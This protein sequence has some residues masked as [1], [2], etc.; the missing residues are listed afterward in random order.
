VLFA[1][2]ASDTR[3]IALV[4]GIFE[5]ADA[6]S[7]RVCHR[8]AWFTPYTS[9]LAFWYVNGKHNSHLLGQVDIV[10]LGQ[11]DSAP[12]RPKTPICR[13]TPKMMTHKQF[14]APARLAAWPVEVVS[15]APQVTAKPPRAAAR[16]LQTY[17]ARRMPRPPNVSKSC[18][19]WID[20]NRPG[21]GPTS[22]CPP[23]LDL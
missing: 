22:C 4:T 17:C 8:T 16:Y 13:R 11:A 10:F 14:P 9:V 2:T 20:T 15:R 12:A 18:K 23:R 21:F 5:A 3:H 1:S 6:V 7:R 19:V